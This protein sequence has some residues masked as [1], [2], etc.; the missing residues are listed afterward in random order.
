MR[1]WS[2]NQKWG[3]VS[4]TREKTMLTMKRIIILISL[5]LLG[6]LWHDNAKPATG[7]VIL[8]ATWVKTGGPIGGLGYDVRYG[9]TWNG[10]IDTSVMYV[11]DNYSG[12]NKSIY[13]GNTWFTS[14]YGITKRTG[15]SGD[16]ISVFSLTVDPNN[17]N[18]IW[19]GLKDNLGVYK[20]NDAGATWQE[21]SLP[22]WIEPTFAFRGFSIQK[23]NSNI[24]YAAGEIPS[25]INGKE[26]NKVRGRV[27]RTAD[28]GATWTTVWEGD[29]L[30]RYIIIHP[31]NPNLLYISTGIFDRE[32]YNSNCLGMPPIN[33][34]GVGVIKATSPDGGTTWVTTQVNNGLTDLYVGSL[35]MHPANPNI[36]LAGSG[37]N[38]CSYLPGY[39]STGGVFLTEDGGQ[40][41]TKTL[42]N[43]SIISVEFSTSRPNVAYAGSKFRFYRS[44]DGGHTW[45]VV[46]GGSSFWWGP[47]GVIAGFP[48]DILVDPSDPFTLFANNYGGGN[49][50]S[51]DGGV[52]WSLAS[53][54]YTGALMF[55]LAINPNSPGRVYATARSGLFRSLD[56][57]DHWYGLTTP[58][59]NEPETYSVVL[60]PDNPQIVLTASEL[61]GNVFRSTDGGSSWTKV[62]TIPGV[63]PGDPTNMQGF[64]RMVFAPS[65]TDLI[66]AGTCAGINLLTDTSICN[67]IYRSLDGGLTWEEAN[68]ENTKF[69]CIHDIAIDPRFPGMIYVASNSDGL[70]KTYNGG[71][72][73]TSLSLPVF[74]VRTVAI[75]PANPDIVYAGTD[76][77]GVYISINQGDSWTQLAT[78]MNA[79]ERIWSI[80]I[81]PAW[82]SEVWA[83][84]LNSGVYRWD[85]IEQLWTLVNSG[86]EMRAISHLEFSTDGSVLY[87][88]TW[89]GGVYRLGN[90]PPL[91]NNYLPAI[92]K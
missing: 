14:N 9:A 26:F 76:G 65:S 85:P 40:S 20:S 69:L 57:G 72:S 71:S 25:S 46:A 68:D 89:G 16:A 23:G 60:K 84:S 90:I 58:P 51:I 78:G 45:S 10:T 92:L 77:S 82:P 43:D 55:D 1:E 53:K 59:I 48:I 79:N 11:T 18:N 5:G 74:D 50:K 2:I 31:N 44:L 41:W 42:S 87:A 37:N 64:K 28:G 17:G 19:V 66:Y 47:P 91:S 81:N 56:G 4:L 62:F 67:G 54:G 29:N 34:G 38:S 80:V 21:V 61:L 75:N 32:A 36:L 35:V 63:I 33:P 86:L 49:V 83:G 6:T 73:W 15:T 22:A 39:V 70:I 12:V 13:G 24:V 27:L 3:Y 88:N 8:P 7:S 52:T 30:A